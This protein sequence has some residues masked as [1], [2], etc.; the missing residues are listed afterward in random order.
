M[1]GESVVTLVGNLTRDPEMKFTASGLAFTKFGLAVNRRWKNTKTDEWDEAVSFFDVVVWRELAEN[2]ASSLAKGNR[3]IASGR[4][5][6][7]SWETDKGE[8]RYAVEM[9]AEH[10]GAELKY[11]TVEIS[12]VERVQGGQ[13]A[14]PPAAPEGYSYGEEPF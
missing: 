10:V 12:K 2:I 13:Q 1:A 8:K 9:V 4:L 11:A 5:E 6:Q 3:V 7:R 14:P